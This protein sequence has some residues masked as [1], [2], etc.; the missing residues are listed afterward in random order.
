MFWFRNAAPRHES[1]RKY[2]YEAD[3]G[4][5]LDSAEALAWYRGAAENGDAYAQYQLG[6]I[7][8]DGSLV[9]VDLAESYYWFSQSA[10]LGESLS[11]RELW[12]IFR[13]G[14]GVARDEHKQRYWFRKFTGW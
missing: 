2:C 10:E 14:R 1:A 3:N 13:D 9:D 7:Y 8:R 11:Y 12:K 4:V 6:C 5:P